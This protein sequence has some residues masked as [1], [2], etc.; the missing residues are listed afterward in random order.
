[1]G[2]GKRRRGL[3]RMK[4]AWVVFAARMIEELI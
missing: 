4:K 2:N 3:R 1:M